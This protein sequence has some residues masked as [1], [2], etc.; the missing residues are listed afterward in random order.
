MEGDASVG[1]PIGLMQLFEEC[2][3]VKGWKADKIE[4]TMKFIRF[5][6]MRARGQIRTGA[7]FIRDFI[8]AHPSYKKDSKLSD[9]IC[10]DLIKVMSELNNDDCEARA[11]LLGEYA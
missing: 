11:D 7:R 1:M 8:N 10:W 9:D 2:M 4:E 3:N 6:A 5:L